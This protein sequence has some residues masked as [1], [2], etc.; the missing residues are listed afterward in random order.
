MQRKKLALILVLT[1]GLA[2]TAA[3]ALAHFGMIIPQKNTVE[4][5]DP[6][7]VALSYLF[8][9]PMENQG[10]E[11]G[12]PVEVG[13]LIDGKKIDLL[14]GLK[15]VKK[16]GMTTWAGSLAIKQPGDYILYMT[17][18]AYW[19]PAE[20]KFIIHYTKTVVSALGLM[21]GWD[22]A[23]GQKVEMIPLTRPYGL[24]AG[25]SFSAKVVYKGQPLANA[26]VEVE[27]YNPDGK[28]KA[29][30]DAYVTQVV[31][32]DAQGQFTW[33]LPWPGW[34]GFA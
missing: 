11:L 1:L 25:N 22:V 12:Q 14:P 15:P 26:D 28:K 9:H 8:W 16:N 4:K 18:P 21:E 23:V 10:L 33:N 3:P 34:W 29:P 2:L 20:D 17:P 19:E 24:W 13:Y 32:T 5:S 31:K 6:K 30:G 27:F 7:T